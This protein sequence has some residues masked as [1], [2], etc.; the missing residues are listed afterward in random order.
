MA[1]HD[2]DINGAIHFGNSLFGSLLTII[3]NVFSDGELLAEDYLIMLQQHWE[4]FVSDAATMSCPLS[5]TDDDIEAHKEHMAAW[6]H[7][8]ELMGKFLAD[9]GGGRG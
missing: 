5:F 8:V 7:S 3:G 2:S 1:C 6:A 9:M 4:Q